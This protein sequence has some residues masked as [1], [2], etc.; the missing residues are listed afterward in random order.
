MPQPQ[1]PLLIEKN[2]VGGGQN[3]SKYGGPSTKTARNNQMRSP[4]AFNTIGNNQHT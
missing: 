2:F 3:F 1:K 4:L